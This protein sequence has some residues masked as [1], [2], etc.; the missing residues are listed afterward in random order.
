VSLAEVPVVLMLIGLAAYA[1]LAGADFGAGFWQLLGGRGRRDRALREHAHHAMGPVWEANHV[2]LIFVLVV[3]WTAY[4]TAF[5]SIASTLA[6]PFFLAGIG[7]VFRGSAYALRSATATTREER[8]VELVFATSSVLTPFALGSIIGGIA[9]GH[10]PVGNARGDLFASWLNPTSITL[11]V[12][13]VATAAYLAA[14]YL[15]ADAVR[16]RRPEL[17]LAFRARALVMAVVAGAAALAGLVVV[18]HDARPIW[19]GLTHGAGIAAVAASA[20]GGAATVVFVW[21]R[22]YAVARVTAAVAVTAIVAGWG[23]AQRPDLLP[24]LTI[25][26]AAAGRATLLALIVSL[27][28]GAVILVPSL[29]LLFSLVLRGRFDEAPAASGAPAPAGG[30]R[31][32]PLLP[33]AA[34]CL[35]LGL[36]AT[37]GVPASWGRIVG[38]PALFAFVVL[39]F[40]WLASSAVAATSRRD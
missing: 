15:A 33:A 12:L 18:R 37:V 36:V 7:I 24:G 26:Q 5:G 21:R 1:V 8:L 11:G 10:V 29:A 23:V 30:A 13:S 3:C 40:L 4:P 17:E 39:G 28:I 38:V 22:R 31:T 34:A 19:D 25:D 32:F 16:L 2:W 27:A 6:I 9:S 20:F 35:G 14:V